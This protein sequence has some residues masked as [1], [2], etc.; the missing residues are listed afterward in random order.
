MQCEERWGK[1]G[2]PCSDAPGEV[3]DSVPC[4]RAHLQCPAG[5]LAPPQLP[6]YTQR[7]VLWSVLEG[8]AVDLLPIKS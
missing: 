2:L 7:H 4:S 8:M 3:R 1:D 6:V 5:E